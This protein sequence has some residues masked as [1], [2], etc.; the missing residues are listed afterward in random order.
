MEKCLSGSVHGRF[1]P[2]HNGHLRYILKAKDY[3]DFLWIGIT[4][5]NIYNLLKSPQDPHRHESFH[6]PFT[7]FERIEMI[8]QA[9]LDNGLSL[10]KFDIIPF[11]IDKPNLLPDFLPITVTIFTT[12][13]DEWNKYKIEVLKK[14][15]YKVEILW[16][17][18]VKTVDG[19]N[20]RNQIL[21]D[22]EIWKRNVPQ[23][24]ID[25]VEK[26]HIRDRLISLKEKSEFI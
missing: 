7:F 24:T 2:L 23:A 16:E 20:I 8:T 3:C 25:V 6:N 10:Y 13:Y 12:I 14:Q 1:Q 26:Y 19:I 21:N 11:P 18:S 17:E 5:Y 9:L 4:Q 15:G 22:N